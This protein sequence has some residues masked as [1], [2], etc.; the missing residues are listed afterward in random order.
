MKRSLLLLIL[1]LLSFSA[2]QESE[3]PK[4]S[5]IP[6]FQQEPGIV[7]LKGTI[8]RNYQNVWYCISYESETTSRSSCQ[9]LNGQA[10]PYI[11]V[12]Q[13]KNLPAG[14]YVAT[15]EIYRAPQRLSGTVTATFI[16]T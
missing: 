9:Q 8:P 1:S 15:L 2:A 7:E 16:V 12:H 11:V 10:G 5:A 13:Y 4:L 6:Q 3:N 14:N